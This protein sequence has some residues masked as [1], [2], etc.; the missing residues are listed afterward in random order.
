MKIDGCYDYMMD[1]VCST[2]YVV[3]VTSIPFQFFAPFHIRG[4]MGK[5]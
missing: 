5:E 1:F 2:F 3:L 4:I